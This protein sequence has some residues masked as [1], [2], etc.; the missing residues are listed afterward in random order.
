LVNPLRGVDVS[1]DRPNIVVLVRD[2]FGWGEQG[3][4]GG[5]V[6]R[7]A[8]TPSFNHCSSMRVDPDRW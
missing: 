5:G 7:G 8:P 1:A 4:Y 6:L 2:S 3:S